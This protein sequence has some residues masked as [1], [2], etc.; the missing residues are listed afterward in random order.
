MRRVIFA[1]VVGLVAGALVAQETPAYTPGENPFQGDFAFVL[2]QAV[3]LRVD[4]QGV[5]LDSVT[6]SAVGE[7]RP[8]QKVKCEAVVAGSNTTD[9]K[10]TLTAVLLLEDADGKKL[11]RVTLDPFRAKAG[12]DFQE[13]QKVFV[14]GDALTGARKVYLFI[15]VAF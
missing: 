11:E 3:G 1:L 4:L 13:R 6:M 12:K 14:G 9:K 10:A 2:G 8:G 5:H 7:V 15:Q